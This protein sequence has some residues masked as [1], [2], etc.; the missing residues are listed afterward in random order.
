MRM[1]EFSR[2]GLRG[3][4]AAIQ[5]FS[6]QEM[7]ERMNYTNVSRRFAVE[8]YFTFPVSRHSFQ[9]FELC[10]VAATAGKFSLAIHLQ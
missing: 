2:N 6:V 5:E 9:V 10:R 7:Q 8:D 1:D 4:H 3:S